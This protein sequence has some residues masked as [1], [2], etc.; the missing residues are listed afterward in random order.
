MN[1]VACP[2]HEHVVGGKQGLI[3]SGK[4]PHEPRA[5]PLT[6]RTRMHVIQHVPSHMAKCHATCC[7][8]AAAVVS[9]ARQSMHKEA[10]SVQTPAG[11]PLWTQ[12]PRLLCILEPQWQAHAVSLPGWHCAPVDTQPHGSG[13]D[14]AACS[15]C[16]WRGTQQYRAGEGCRV[17][18]GA[19]GIRAGWL[20]RGGQRRTLWNGQAHRRG[21]RT[22]PAPLLVRHRTLL[23][24]PARIRPHP[25]YC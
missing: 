4:W 6:A 23:A 11:E 17:Q 19:A 20:P 5:R 24:D 18:A 2:A 14:T 12:C 9:T 10:A 8:T 3:A 13:A 22:R 25:G 21:Y 16:S 7:I 1:Y 15:L